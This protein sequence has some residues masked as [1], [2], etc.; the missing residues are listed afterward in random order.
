[1]GLL[2]RPQE[3]REFIPTLVQD[4]TKEIL[5]AYAGEIELLKAV[6]MAG[7]FDIHK[8]RQMAMRSFARAIDE[9]KTD[10]MVIGS[11]LKG[12]LQKDEYKEVAEKL[13]FKMGHKVDVRFMLTHPIVADFRAS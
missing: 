4:R 11:S 12:L 3:L 10:I 2:C 9:E 13:R 1:S 5:E 7:V 6:R 8:R